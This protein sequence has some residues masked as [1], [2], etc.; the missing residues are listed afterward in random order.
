MLYVVVDVEI[1]STD[2]NEPEMV[3]EMVILLHLS[4]NTGHSNPGGPV[5]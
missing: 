2:N 5:W 3:T 4:S 1:I